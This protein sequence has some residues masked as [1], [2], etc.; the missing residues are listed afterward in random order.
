MPRA[1]RERLI[2]L[3]N[4][5]RSVLLSLVCTRIIIVLALLLALI[6]V[7]ATLFAPGIVLPGYD[8]LPLTITYLC[9]CLPALGALWA[10]DRLLSAVR[11]EQVFT[12]ANVR[13]LRIISWCCFVAGAILLIG[14]FFVSLNLI[15]LAVLAAFFGIVI[16]VVKNLFEAAVALKD[17]NDFTI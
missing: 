1:L 4:R 9:F 16:R 10:L 5:D 11:H 12:A 15:I 2:A 3:W 13:L 7:L 6:L 8:P 17:E 14:C